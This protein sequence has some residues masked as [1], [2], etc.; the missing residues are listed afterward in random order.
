ML[1]EV[2]PFLIT[3]LVL[4]DDFLFIFQTNLIL[5][6][7]ESLEILKSIRRIIRALNIE[8]KSIEQ[9]YGLS[10]PQFLLLGYLENSTDYK[11]AQKEIKQALNLNSSTITGIIDRLVKRGYVV[12]L[13]KS[14]D[15]RVTYVVLTA[16]GL[17]LL[18]EAPNV[19]HDRLSQ[20]LDKLS[21]QE[22]EMVHQ[23]LQ[24]IT[25]AMEI[26]E[27]DASGLLTS[28]SDII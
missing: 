8:S 1:R 15:K 26:K 21:K 7:M 16:T 4:A 2:Q 27:V 3:L 25:N 20:K 13:P 18:E 9:E 24:I 11:S 17:K 6:D 12:R 28:N 23:S 5:A 14:G 19:L 10:I 22:K